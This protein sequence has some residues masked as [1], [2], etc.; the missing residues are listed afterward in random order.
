MV[1]GLTATGAETKGDGVR[2]TCVGVACGVVVADCTTA[3]A[4]GIDGTDGI[5]GMDVMPFAVVDTDR[6]IG[7]IE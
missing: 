3:S 1:V 4:I 2:Y 6:D 7:G 5:D